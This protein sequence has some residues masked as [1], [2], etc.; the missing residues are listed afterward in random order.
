MSNF[1]RILRRSSFL[2]RI[3]RYFMVKKRESFPRLLSI[4]LTNACN[5]D[6][7]MCPRS[8]LTRKITQMD[9]N[10]FKKIIDECKGQ[11]LKKI[12]LFWFG[13][14]FIYPKLPEAIKYIKENLPKVKL[15]ISTNGALVKSEIAEKVIKAGLDT[16]NF[17][18]DGAT[19][20][21]F[22]SIRK[23]LDFNQVTENAKNFMEIRKRLGKNKPKVSV[24]IIKMDKT[25]D[26]IDTF[27]E[28]WKEIVDSIGVNDYNTWLGNVE[29]RN[30]GEKKEVSKAGKFTF[31]CDHPFNEL[32]FAVDG[33]V[34]MCCLDWDCSEEIGDINENTVKEIWTG[35][36][37]KEKRQL[38]IDNKYDQIPICKNCNSYIF[39]E[40]SVWANVWQ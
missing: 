4:E 26:E 36:K 6:C 13:E 27:K 32:A 1:N 5:S 14:T 35:E 16:I 2:K 29:D 11:K 15:N 40:K 7:I 39:Q 25:V 20:D 19:K 31:P 22:E 18:I 37:M 3:I 28:Q 9:F 33:T 8:K 34:S 23:N 38:M 10:L 21:T 17:D 24:T 12:N 30:V